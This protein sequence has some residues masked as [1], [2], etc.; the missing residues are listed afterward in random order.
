MFG[1][2][3]VLCCQ[4]TNYSEYGRQN[5]HKGRNRCGIRASGPILVFRLCVYSMQLFMNPRAAVT[6]GVLR[7]GR[8]PGLKSGSV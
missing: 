4:I 2:G 6:L 7:F 8:G 3:V 1:V 5:E